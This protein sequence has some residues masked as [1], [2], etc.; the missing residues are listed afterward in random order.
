MRFQNRTFNLASAIQ[1]VFVLA[2]SEGGGTQNVQ[3]TL[4]STGSCCSSATIPLT[5]TPTITVLGRSSTAFQVEFKENSQTATGVTF[6]LK[7]LPANESLIFST[8]Q[9]GFDT[10]ISFPFTVGGNKAL[11]LGILPQG[12]IQTILQNAPS[13]VGVTNPSRPIIMGQIDPFGTATQTCNGI[14]NVQLVNKSD[15]LPSSSVQ[16]PFYFNSSGTLVTGGFSD[17]QCS[18][19]FF[20]VLEGEYK[21]QFLVTNPSP[22]LIAEHEVL[23]INNQVSFGLGIP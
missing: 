15:D 6:T 7:G 10:L 17:Q 20:N 2:C 9:A 18:Y 8:F 19:I 13:E 23:A 16:G 3:G 11:A 22:N 12:T 14:Q 21:I 1:L 4:A 5:P